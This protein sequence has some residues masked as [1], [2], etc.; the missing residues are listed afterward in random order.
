MLVLSITPKQCEDILHAELA[1]G[2]AALNGRVG[3]FALSLLQVEDAL[4]DRVSDGKAVD[5]YVDGL[6]ESV[7]AINGLLFYKLC[8]YMR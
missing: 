8:G 4:F 5:L 3:E 2:L 1:N 7:D 6:I